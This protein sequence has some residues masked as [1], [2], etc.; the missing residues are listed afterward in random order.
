MKK[1]YNILKLA[2]SCSA[3]MLI[4]S[5]CSCNKIG[6]LPLQKDYIYN[7]NSINSIGG[8][9]AW[10]YIKSRGIGKGDSLFA[11]ME[12]GIRYCGIDTN[13]YMKS[14]TTYIVYTDSAIFSHTATINKKTHDTTWTKISTNSYYG[15][16]TISKVAA[17]SWSFYKG[18]YLDT[19]KFNLMYLIVNGAHSF[20]NIPITY[21]SLSVIPLTT[22]FE[23]DTTL[24]PQ[25]VTALNPN[26]LISF[27]QSDS[28]ANYASIYL[29]A[30]PGSKFGLTTSNTQ[31]PG[32]KVR[33]AGVTTKNNS[34]IHV[35]DKVLFYQRK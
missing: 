32:L 33:T 14:N 1:K 8:N 20:N 6:N 29:N 16:Y 4:I 27:N 5:F 10:D 11:L 30:F 22:P 35:I 7:A 18:P 19:V 17:T 34:V 15:K 12:Q 28:S 25:G 23:I 26:S 9:T 2:A 24:M 21:S 31:F 13:L 3:I